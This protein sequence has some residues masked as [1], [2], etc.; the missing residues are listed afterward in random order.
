[1]LRDSLAAAAN[2]SLLLASLWAIATGPAFANGLSD[3]E[4]FIKTVKTAR[5]DFTQVVTSPAK[6]GQPP[7]SKMS[8]GSF[9]FSRP[10]RF[11]FVYKKPFEQTLVADG[12]TV[13]LYDLDLNQ[14]TAR[15]QAAVLGSTPAALLASATDMR[16]LEADF[17]LL[18]DGAANGLEWVHATPKAKDSS[19]QSV[20]VGFA[21][22]NL[23]V[24]EILDSF[25]QKS[26][27]SFS[28]FKPNVPL[29][30]GTFQ[31]TPPAGAD[32][33]RQ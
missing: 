13:W 29:D 12:K 28:H 32:I 9:E 25:G 21:V 6:E 18:A 15:K 33:I 16:A 11:K 5:T 17:V 24:L 1:M 2:K 7:R 19:L 3:L 31:F 22:G 23:S 30:S 4:N 10:G 8:T 14:V 27:L 20:R 26:T